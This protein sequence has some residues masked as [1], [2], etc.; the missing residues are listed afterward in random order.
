M[1]SGGVCGKNCYWISVSL[2]AGACMGTGA[3]IFASSF[4]EYG[5]IGTG[6]LAPGPFF[7]C[8]IIRLFQE[9]RF[10]RRTGSWF[11]KEGSRVKTPE[12]K[13]IWKSL[14]PVAVNVITN[15][16]YLIVI[17]IGWKL[18]KASGLN[19]GVI[20]TL[21]STASLINVVAFYFKF[22]EKISYMHFLGIILML[23]CV[24]CIS[25]AAV[26]GEE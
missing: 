9:I 19:Q 2:L 6:I 20:S 16:L 1:K 22:G 26:G 4:S 11:K 13:I 7:F 24:L 21:L 18:A 25:M 3:F 12:G 10:R 5:M 23:G 14:I 17:T 15:A 8:L